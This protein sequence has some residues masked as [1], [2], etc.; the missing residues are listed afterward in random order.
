MRPSQRPELG[1]FPTQAELRADLALIARIADSIRTYS[2]D[3][4]L[5]DIPRLAGEVGLD[6]T[7]GVWLGTDSARNRRQVEALIDLVAASP[8]VSR[9]IIGNETQLE[10]AVAADE[11]YA[12]LDL[13]RS[14]IDVPV[15]TAEPWHIWLSQS[16]LTE[17]VDFLT[18]HLLPYW[19]GFSAARA[20]ELIDARIASLQTAYPDLPAVIGEVGWPS[21]GRSRGAA[22]ASP[23]EAER[24]LR[25]YLGAAQS[26]GDDYFLM[27][28]IDQPWKQSIEGTVG[29]HWGWFDARRQP[30]YALGASG[31]SVAR[32]SSMIRR[33]TR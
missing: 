4:T 33:S 19:E 6:V 5:A 28:A 14:Q 11:L 32:R 31:G 27:E 24:F 12:L 13:A 25:H 8:N 3:G 29:A 1:E 30:K 20:G 16:E 15:S 26:R 22:R 9:V 18:A 23:A 17:H 2:I 21:N 10:G 7:L